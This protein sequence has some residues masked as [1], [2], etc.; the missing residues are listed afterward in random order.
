MKSIVCGLAAALLLL[1]PTQS[2]AQ[3]GKPVVAIYQMD[4]LTRSG[5]AETF[6]AMI[7]TAIETTNKFRVIER[8]HLGTLVGEQQRAKA[9]LVTSNHP[10]KVGGFEGADFLI[11]GTITTLSLV[12]KA[13][14]G[15]NIGTSFVAGLLGARNQPMPNCNDTY[16]TLGVD[17]K[18]TDADTGE[19]R[20]AT[21]IN[22]KQKSSAAG[23]VAVG[24]IDAAALLRSA[25]DNVATDLVTTIYPI[26]IAA[27]EPD[28][29]IVLN[30]GQGRRG[31]R[32]CDGRLLQGRSHPRSRHR[33]SHRQRRD[34]PR[35]HQDHRRAGPHLQGDADQRVHFRAGHRLHRQAGDRRRH[36][37]ARR[38]A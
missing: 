27:V 1:A 36:A 37:Q 21:R 24:Q 10:G 9:G 18:I 4:D 3:K 28:G 7:E 38:H 33:R 13:D 32:V 19:V 17:I 25:A 29:T 20:Y 5:Q 30:Y 35:L 8:Q 34:E 6:S 11:Y 12:S 2:F 31:T 15:A 16:A 22:E 26:Q 23:G 14:F